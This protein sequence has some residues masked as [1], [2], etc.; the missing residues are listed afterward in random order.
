LNKSSPRNHQERTAA[1][2]EAAVVF[3]LGESED[4]SERTW[5]IE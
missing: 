1:P 5:T 4:L 2:E 3:L